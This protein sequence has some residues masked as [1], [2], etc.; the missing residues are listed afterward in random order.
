M[1]AFFLA[2]WL[3][4]TPVVRIQVY[5]PVGPTPIRVLYRVDEARVR[6]A[7]TVIVC[8]EMVVAGSRHDITDGASWRVAWPLYEPCL[9][10][11]Q[12]TAFDAKNKQ[13]GF[14]SAEFELK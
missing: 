4:A 14:A 7:D 11:A 2:L 13:I 8:D 6:Y 10:S 1:A 3:L 5:N 12:I 9:Y